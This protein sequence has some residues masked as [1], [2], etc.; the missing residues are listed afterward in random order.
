MKKLLI[1]I[2]ALIFSV[3]VHA[4]Y[5]TAAYVDSDLEVDTPF[6]Q[7]FDDDANGFLIGYGW[8]TAHPWLAIELTYTDFGDSNKTLFEDS[9]YYTETYNNSYEGEA[10]DLWLV[11]RFSPISIDS[12]RKVNIVPRVGLSAMHSRGT[13]NYTLEYKGNIYSQSQ[14]ADDA[15]IGY[16]YGLGIEI[17]H[18]LPNTD[19]FIDWRKHEGEMVYLGHVVDFDPSSIQA[20][21]NWHF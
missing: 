21:V 9:G 3:S 4:D 12:K 10:L 5:L 7:A 17:T 11:G 18:V 16:A 13:I 20:G 19:F 2:A 15:T 1:G 8:E 14:S 6:N